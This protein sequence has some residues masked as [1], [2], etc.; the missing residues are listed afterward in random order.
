MCSIAFTVPIDSCLVYVWHTPTN[1][2]IQSNKIHH[3]SS[4][5]R[6]FLASGIRKREC[7]DVNWRSVGV[8]AGDHIVEY[9]HIHSIVCECLVTFTS[10]S[11]FYWLI[12]IIFIGLCGWH[13]CDIEEAIDQNCCDFVR[14]KVVSIFESCQ[15]KAKRRN[16]KW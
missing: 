9:F 16:S 8:I 5:F 11:I 15:R 2:N 12:R 1:S 14:Q 7:K 13:R 4:T 10:F 3:F 6:S